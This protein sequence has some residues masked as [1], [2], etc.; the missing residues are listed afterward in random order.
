M[1]MIKLTCV[2]F[3]LQTFT[4]LAHVTFDFTY[5]DPPKKGF[6]AR[7]EAKAALEEVAKR[8][9]DVWLK[10]HF[11]D[12]AIKVVSIE[13]ETTQC[14]HFLDINYSHQYRNGLLYSS[15]QEKIFFRYQNFDDDFYDATLYVNFSCP[16]SFKDEVKENQY[17]FKALMIYNITKLLGFRS[18]NLHNS[19][20]SNEDL[21]QLIIA[22]L[23]LGLEK[24]SRTTESKLDE[25]AIKNQY[26]SYGNF[27]NT[28]DA[29]LKR[30]LLNKRIRTSLDYIMT[31]ALDSLE[32]AE[33]IEINIIATN[34]LIHK[35]L[36][37]YEEEFS[38]KDNLL[39]QDKV[40][41][42]KLLELFIARISEATFTAFD[43]FLTYENGE[44]VFNKAKTLKA[45][46]TDFEQKSKESDLFFKR[47]HTSGALLD[48][49]WSH[50]L[51]NNESI[52]SNFWN[53]KG[54]RSRNWDKQTTQIMLDLGYKVNNFVTRKC[55]NPQS[56]EEN[57][58]E[59][60]DILLK[61]FSTAIAKEKAKGKKTLE[62]ELKKN[63]AKEKKP[64]KAKLKKKVKQKLKKP[65]NDL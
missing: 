27:Y 14:S 43:Q 28:F 40:N 38:D 60:F 20:S 33:D 12:I 39:N 26:L 61:K 63:K 51:L 45:I 18:A 52:M 5:F 25:A 9:G 55:D 64:G 53:Q 15:A 44:R 41:F 30:T 32:E 22:I 6:N 31:L 35:E 56:K 2:V 46:R 23:R 24:L 48:K 47:I 65:K 57:C 7:P 49:N 58:K 17:D 21:E 3:L 10:Y 37:I 29:V 42:E 34:H 16:F 36:K 19:K 59:D 8:I 54:L 1:K 62:K 4:A 13:D 50:V 11:A